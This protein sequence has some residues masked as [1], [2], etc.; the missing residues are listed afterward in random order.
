MRDG[1]RLYTAIYAPKSTTTQHPILITRTPYSI[2]PYGEDKLKQVWRSYHMAYYKKEYIMVYQDVRGRMM[3]E[4]EFM[5]VRPFNVDK[6]GT[7]IDEASDTYDL[8]DWLVKNVPNNNG[9][10]GIFGISYPGFYA[11]MGALSGHPALKASSPQAPVTEWFL[12]DDFHHNGAF[13]QLDAFGFYSSFGKPRPKP[14]TSFAGGFQTKVRDNYKFHLEAGTLRNLAK[15]MG[16][17]ITFWKELYDHPNYDEWWQVRNVRN[18]V[19]HIPSNTAT[20]VVGGL[21]DAEDC[22]GAWELYK[23]IEK[24]TPN[25]NKLVM[26]PWSHGGWGRGTGEFLGNVR[27]GSKTSTWYQE[28]IEIPYFEHHLRGVGDLNKLPEASI[29]LTGTN[30]WR[31]FDKWPPAQAQNKKIYLQENGSLSAT[32]PANTT[33]YKEYT[34]DPSKPVPY[35]EDVHAGRTAEYMTDDQ[36]F[37]WRRPDVLSFTSKTLQNDLTVTGPVIA[38]L[39]TS[40]STSDADFVVKLIDVFPD[41]FSY[42]DSVDGIGNGKNYPMGGYQMLVRSEIMRGRYRNSFTYPEA[43]KPGRVTEVSYQLPD[44]AHVFK[45]GHKLMIQIQSTWFPLADR[46]PQQFVNIYTCGEEDFV[47]SLIRIYTN[48][49]YPSNIELPVL[50]D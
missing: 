12:G 43:F 6:K 17:S 34:S 13:M 44:V 24:K 30:T 48:S 41:D 42:T 20:L 29:F 7:T 36:R 45:K 16:D 2:A 25:N 10:A 15:L 3:S 9:R 8:I 14:T 5:D 39:F 32:E 40:I 21:F 11:T 31:T 23:A 49:R 4:G 28:N 18:H 22:F 19:Q 26:G 37:A 33:G 1:A 47:S 46:N 38:N 50:A 35:T 27:F